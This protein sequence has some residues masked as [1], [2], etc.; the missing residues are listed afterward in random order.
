M[1]RLPALAVPGPTAVLAGTYSLAFNNTTYRVGSDGSFENLKE[2]ATGKIT[3]PEVV[4]P[5]LYG[6]RVPQRLAAG[7]PARYTHQIDISV[8]RAASRPAGWPEMA[9]VRS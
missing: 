8:S 4:T 3:G 2:T 6:G 9:R 1:H 7:F 5:P